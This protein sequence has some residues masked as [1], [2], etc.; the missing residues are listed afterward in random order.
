MKRRHLILTL[1]GASAGAMTIGSGAFSSAQV[2]RG[3]SVSVVDDDHALVGY[4][5]PS[6]D[7]DGKQVAHGEQ[8]GLVTVENRFAGDVEISIE[9]VTLDVTPDNGEYPNVTE[10]TYDD[11]T[12]GPGHSETIKGAIECTDNGE[13]ATVELTVRVTGEGVSA[14]LFGDTETRRFDI[15]SDVDTT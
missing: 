10:V 8:V 3:V 9:D 6:D 4:D 7:V 13:R 14:E 2:E 11:G 15:V 12:F 1:G 5:S